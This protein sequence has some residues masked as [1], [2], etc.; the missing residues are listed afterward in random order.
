M[1]PR[2]PFS[3]RGAACLR[4]TAAVLLAALLLLG[5]VMPTSA[6]TAVAPVPLPEAVAAWMRAEAPQVVS[7]AT[8]GGVASGALTFGDVVKVSAWDEGFLRGEAQG[9]GLKDSAHWAATVQVLGQTVG[10]IHMWSSAE[11]SA[12]SGPTAAGTAGARGGAAS[13]AATAAT[14]AAT[15]AASG[16]SQVIDGEYVN[17]PMLGDALARYSG[18]E[19]NG[20]ASIQ[21]VIVH[22]PVDRSWFAVNH[23][24]VRPLGQTS[25]SVL[26]G[27]LPVAVYSQIVRERR[28]EVPV[29]DKPAWNGW[30]PGNQMIWLALGGFVALALVV[31]ITVRHER[32]AFPD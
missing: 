8:P 27:E 13:A 25:T 30:L 4:P 18:Q 23:G 32:Q 21:W 11:N 14:T 9:D 22:D 3:P 26:A 19:S 6:A 28:A 24:V 7:N 17:D 1:T 29:Q 2:S 10:A 15:R 12:T 16:I 20:E 5:L 31:V